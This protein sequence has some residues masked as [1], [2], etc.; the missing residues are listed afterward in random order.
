MATNNSNVNMDGQNS[1]WSWKSAPVSLDELLNFEYDGT[2][3]IYDLPPAS[4]NLF[5]AGNMCI[6]SE[7]AGLTDSINSARD[8]PRAFHNAQFRIQSVSVKG[9]DMTFSQD[10]HLTH[11]DYFTGITINKVVTVKWLEDA[12]FSVFKY[13]QDWLCNWYDSRNDC[14]LVGKNGKFRQLD[15]VAFHYKQ[16]KSIYES[17]TVE[18][19]L[20]IAIRGMVPEGIPSFDF[21]VNS[22]G[23]VIH[24][25]NYHVNHAALFYNEAL[26]KN[27]NA[28]NIYKDTTV[29][30]EVIWAPIIANSV[31]YSDENNRI[32]HQVHS[33][34]PSEGRMM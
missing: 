11:R 3:Y 32:L 25:I 17:P 8:A 23:T 10:A 33:T 26:E 21:D 28:A 30:S 14:F 4:N 22:N 1:Y 16:S 31:N 5:W 12:Y 24:S 2:N 13:H 15:V 9:L 20:L 7:G 6:P 27:N 18:P 29:Q 34:L 19:I